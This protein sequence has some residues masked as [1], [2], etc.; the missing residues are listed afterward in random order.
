MF[1]IASASLR[2]VNILMTNALY[3][4]S[5]WLVL[6][7][8][9]EGV[10]VKNL[11]LSEQLLLLSGIPLC[12]LLVFAGLL[13]AHTFETWRN[14]EQTVALERVIDA[15]DEYTHAIPDEAITSLAA[16]DTGS[17]AMLAKIP[18][19]RRRANAAVANL[20]RQANAS[21]LTDPIALAHLNAALAIDLKGHYARTDARTETL[22]RILRDIRGAVQQTIELVGRLGVLS[23]SPA[24]SRLML[25]YNVAL[26][27][28][29]ALLVEHSVR[30]IPG[31]DGKLIPDMAAGEATAVAQQEVLAMQ[32]ERLADP[33]VLPAW[34]RFL[35][36][37]SARIVEIRRRTILGIGGTLD[38]A[39]L[40]SWNAAMQARLDQMAPVLVQSAAALRHMVADLEGAAVRALAGY[41]CLVVVSFVLV[42]ALIWNTRRQLAHRIQC[43][44]GAMRRLADG[45][46]DTLIP[47]VGRADE[48]GEMA[49]TLASFKVSLVERD[50]LADSER[51]AAAALRDE[52]ERLRVTLHAI[53]DG[54][55][56]TGSGR[57]VTMMNAAA[58]QL[59]GW[60]SAEALG[61]DIDTVLTL[62]NPSG[63]AAAGRPSDACPD[64]RANAE[65]AAELAA[66]STLIR[67]DG[68]E[69]AVDASAARIVGQD[70]KL[71][72]SITVLHD[73]TDS[74]LLLNRIRQLAHYDSLTGLPNRALFHDRLAQAVSFA[75]RHRQICALLFLDM[76]RFKHVNDTLGHAV[77]D[78]LLREV[79][80]RLSGTVRESDTVARLGGDE[81][82]VILRNL[83]EPAA[84]AD[85]ARKILAAISHI[86]SIAG[87]EV[88]VSFS[89][90]IAIF[91]RDAQDVDEL[92]MRADAAMYQAKDSGR[93]ACVFFDRDMDRATQRRHQLRLQL[94]K[95]LTL[96]QFVLLFQ[97]KVDLRTGAV[98]GAEA[99]IRWHAADG[100]VIS[101]ADFIP[102]AEETGLIVPIG[103]WVVSQACRQM[104]GWADQGLPPMPVSV[105]VSMKSLHN[106]G[107]LA[108]LRTALR[109]TGLPE[110][111]LEIEI[112]ESAAMA[113]PE[114][115]LAILADIR[116]LGV[117]VSIDD[118][119]TGFSSL[120][121]LRRLP[122]DT[123][124]IDKSFVNTMVEIADD[125]ALVRA[126]I[127][128]ARTM[129]K[130][131]IAEGV[132][133]EAQRALLVEFG[134]L[135]AQGFLFSKPV[136]P[137]VF[138]RML[139]APR[140][141]LAESV[142]G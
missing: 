59:T 105:N 50:R 140:D 29:D 72:G 125:A 116:A 52:K 25:A 113:D 34:H 7:G 112:T 73:V 45:D 100:T 62:R 94:A 93:N 103:E 56:V 12:A 65:P 118:F 17:A 123:I 66:D 5:A 33:D 64:P 60:S 120:S 30:P 106:A 70:G 85:V 86:N 63:Q 101:P 74:R 96:D 91:P 127:G 28:N 32:F 46:L 55:I 40:D 16:L 115:T 23:K 117:G 4:P 1:E 102:I 38:P 99:L 137:A 104:R 80:H 26:C 6:R 78:L 97:P 119:G 90:G 43:L 41:A 95:A 131:V 20:R 141:M 39:G 69:L 83:T 10:R 36:D 142:P 22:S 87:H 44:S 2:S 109:D 121:R 128:L 61:A 54:V 77:G 138:A 13:A 15:V 68:S 35:A 135:E 71:I 14:V 108:T 24:V 134:C 139:Q 132:E 133:T 82:V 31:P 49:E 42:L 76:D 75:K 89:V 19:A 98:T 47:S 111:L 11:S 18:S 130:H 110:H 84:A 57:Q 3:F 122:V 21:G 37:P 27:M 129:R 107:F 79:G 9:F 8:R 114:R 126:I 92:L 124:K 136:H 81:F 53:G 88:N 51:E 67:R 48:L 58:E